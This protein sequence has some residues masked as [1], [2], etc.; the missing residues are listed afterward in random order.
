[1]KNVLV[2]ANRLFKLGRLDA[3]RDLYLEFSDASPN[4]A[5]LV[6]NQ[7]AIIGRRLAPNP[8]EVTHSTIASVF[9]NV[10]LVNMSKSH[11]DRLRAV[12]HL[13]ARGVTHQLWNATDGYKGSAFRDFLRYKERPLGSLTRYPDMND[14]E[15][16]RKKHYI[17][18]AGA[19]GYIHTYISII[20]DAKE[21]GLQRILILEDDVLLSKNFEIE[22]SKFIAAVPSDWVVLNLGSSQYDWSSVDEPTALAKGYYSAERIHTCGSFAIGLDASIYD[23]LIEAARS[24]ESPFD[25]LPLGEI[26][27]KHPNR[28]LVAFPNIVMP[29]V[30]SSSIRGSRDQLSHAKNMRWNI[31][32]FHYPNALPIVCV[33]CD[34]KESVMHALSH[35]LSL[36]KFC[37]F[38]IFVQSPDGIRPIHM[39]LLDAADTELL[40]RLSTEV[41]THCDGA[42]VAL[43]I[44]RYK[45][46]LDASSLISSKEI[47]DKLYSIAATAK[48]EFHVN[49]ESEFVQERVSVVIPTYKRAVGLRSAVISVL[50]QDYSDIEI[51]IVDDNGISSVDAQ[52][53]KDVFDELKALPAGKLLRLIQHKTNRNGAAARNTGIYNSTGEYI[54]FL[55]DDDLYLPGRI[56]KSIEKIKNTG[57]WIGAVY[58]GFLGWNSP[59]NHPERYPEGDLT[60]DLFS[61]SYKNHYMHTN[62]VTYKRAAVFALMGFDESFKRHQ[63][64]EFNLRFFEKYRIV[65][66]R[67][68][69]VKLKVNPGDVD[70]RQLGIDFFVTK[71]RFLMKFKYLIDQF[72][73]NYIQKIYETHAAEVLRVVDKNII[74]TL[75]GSGDFSNYFLI[76]LFESTQPKK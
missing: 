19:V 50:E 67:H 34:G 65:A 15:I 32:N 27:Q 39:D 74:R 26:Y 70:N 12:T 10:Y 60:K 44:A 9:Q 11:G 62:T 55:D 4:F 16:W 57:N 21:R 48:S 46:N 59:A 43:P 53:V 17:E 20:N 5:H 33:S 18:S 52:S 61:L 38:R 56:S 63:D 72:D 51:I 30:S 75:F 31:E 54:C 49:T 58:C 6:A 47:Y 8:S 45:L 7:L 22:F 1:M 42:K 41:R 66:T 68:S 25:L 28:C 23:L 14:R 71:N 76:N 40:D 64:I 13:N 36:S 3:A 69:G 35:R 2:S 29:D 37:D 73:T 24:L